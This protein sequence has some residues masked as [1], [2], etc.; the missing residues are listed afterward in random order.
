MDDHLMVSNQQYGEEDLQDLNL[1]R[2]SDYE[3]SVC[4]FMY[5]MKHIFLL[6]LLF[7]NVITKK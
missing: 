3:N 6:E 2:D 5:G 7:K 4:K 1:D